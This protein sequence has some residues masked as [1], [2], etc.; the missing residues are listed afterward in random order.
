MGY[1][2]SPVFIGFCLSSTLLSNFASIGITLWLSV[3]VEAVAAKG[4]VNLAFYLGIYTAISVAEVFAGSAVVLVFARGAWS[5]AGRLHR[6]FIDAVMHAPLSWFRNVPLG[7]IVNRVS[8]DMMALDNSMS[9]MMVTFVNHF[10]KLLLSVVAISSILPVFLL[11]ALLLSFIGISAGEMYTR[12]SVVVKKLS[13]SAGSPVFSQFSDTLAG[14][15]VIRSRNGMP[16]QFQNRLAEH[17][18]AYAKALSAGYSMSSGDRPLLLGRRA[19]LTCTDISDCNRW[20]AVR[21]DIAAALVM[22]SAGI[23]A[24]SKANSLPVALVGFSLTNAT[25]LSTFSHAPCGCC[26]VLTI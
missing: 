16:E 20:V 18:R 5:A 23:I 6:M 11:P 22:V 25:N 10:V 2:G 14:L 8:G 3:W 13:T 21:V 24:V 19:A 4:A 17:L 1:F 26:L 7:R 12:T 15:A 9:Q